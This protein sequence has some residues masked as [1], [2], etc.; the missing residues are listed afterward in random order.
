MLNTSVTPP[1]H[2]KVNV[3]IRECCF[4]FLTLGKSCVPVCQNVCINSHC[5][6]NNTCKCNSGYKK[7]DN[8]RCLPICEPSCGRN[9]ACLA[10]N[11]CLC[12]PEYKKVNESYCEPT[13]LFTTDNFDCIN[14][15]CVAPNV[16]ECMEGFKMVSEFQCEPICANCEN[17]DCVSPEVCDCHTGYEKNANGICEPSCNPSCL[18][19]KCVAPNTCE[20]DDSFEKYLKSHE[21][22]EKHVIKDRQSC[23]KSCQ[24]GTCNDDGTCIC[25]SGYEMY[26]GK[27][28]KVCAKECVNGKCLEDQCVCP[29]NYKLSE[30]S[31]GCVPICA[32]E[33]GHDCISGTCVAPNVCEC[34]DGYRFLDDR[35]CTCGGSKQVLLNYSIIFSDFFPLVPKCIPQCINAICTDKGCICHENFY[36]ISDHECIKNCSEGFKWVY[37]DCIEESFFELFETDDSEGIDVSTTELVTSYKETTESDESYDNVDSFE[38]P[39]ASTVKS[40]NL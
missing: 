40:I 31:S 32:F 39:S 12:K 16:C 2:Y 37:D 10:P 21:C 22:L 29:F 28:L 1:E 15:K 3:T 17:G 9:M 18:N 25:Q 20:C 6:G 8:F 38:S 36:N 33:D 4:G 7:V 30:N 34:Y 14:A 27:C 19:G 23:E 11:K 13:C 5:I 35:N 26:N 24:H